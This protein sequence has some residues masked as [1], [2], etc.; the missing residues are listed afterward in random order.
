MLHIPEVLCHGQAGKAYPHTGS[1][2]LVHLT[3]DHGGLFDN[4]GLG[5]FPVQV[6]TLTGTLTHAGK[7]GVTVVGGSHIINQLLNQHR[8]THAG[9]A[10]QTDLTTL[11][12]GAN[13][14]DNLD[15]G[16][17]DGGGGLLLVIGGGLTVDGPLL[18]A[19]YLFAAVDGLSQQVKHPSQALLAHRHLNGSA[20]VLC[21]CSP[22]QSIGGAHGNAPHHIVTNVLGGLCHDGIVPIVHMNGTQELR[23]AVVRKT[24]IQNGTH[25]LNHRSH[26]FGH[27]LQLLACNQLS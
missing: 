6:V 7:H 26:I 20:G 4:T 24:N 8:L 11:G 15:A 21:L 10:E 27:W 3:V 22:L 23:K 12:I 13:Q 16:F 25:D 1:G 9:A 17:Q 5:H 14:V 18:G 19:L 2:G